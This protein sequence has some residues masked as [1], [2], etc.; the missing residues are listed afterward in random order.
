MAILR[1]RLYDLDR[2]IVRT[3]SHAL[4]TALLAG[5]LIGVLA[6]S[7]DVLPFSSRVGVAASTLVAAALFNPLRHRVQRAVAPLQP[8]PL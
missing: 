3:V 6:L 4:L 2:L 7:T 1:Y 5:A 8:R